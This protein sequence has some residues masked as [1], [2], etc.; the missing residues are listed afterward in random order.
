[1]IIQFKISLECLIKCKTKNQTEIGQQVIEKN[2]IIKKTK[3]IILY[4]FVSSANI[5]KGKC[6]GLFEACRLNNRKIL[7]SICQKHNLYS[8]K[9]AKKVN[10][11]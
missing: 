4:Q 2:T 11:K 10:N 7:I 9:T 1:M 3:K 5:G 6:H 8:K